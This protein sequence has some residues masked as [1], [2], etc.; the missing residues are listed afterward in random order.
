MSFW[1]EV[2]VDIVLRVVLY[3]IVALRTFALIVSVHP[4]CTRKFTR[5]VIDRARALSSKMS[6]DRADCHCYSIA[7]IFRSWTF[8]DPYFS[9]HKQ[10]I[11]KIVSTLSK[12][13]QKINLGILLACGCKARETMVAKC[14][15]VL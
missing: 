7:W 11:F 5:H 12:N 14:E 10:I 6:N 3:V 1:R 8:D 15:L 13:E 4:Y 9:L 2:D